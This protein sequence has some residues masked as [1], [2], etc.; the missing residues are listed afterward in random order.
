MI[1]GAKIDVLLGKTMKSVE[2][3]N[4]EELLFTTTEGDRYLLYYEPD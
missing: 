1:V 4:D 3:K 2:N